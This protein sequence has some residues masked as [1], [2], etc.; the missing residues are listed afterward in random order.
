[1]A[2]KSAVANWTVTTPGF[3]P[4]SVTVTLANLPLSRTVYPAAL[5]CTVNPV[6][7]GSAVNESRARRVELLRNAL[8]TARK[9]SPAPNASAGA[10]GSVEP[11]MC[12][13]HGSSNV[14]LALTRAHA[15][16]D[17]APLA[18]SLCQRMTNSLRP[19]V[20]VGLS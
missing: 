12:T 2:V 14:P 15:K 17:S 8:L 11:G 6:Y 1:M 10:P 5:N 9:R 3:L 7:G 13:G 16:S 19:A 4:A 20:T 18:L